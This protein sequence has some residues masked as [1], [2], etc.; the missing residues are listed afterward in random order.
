MKLI[1]KNLQTLIIHKPVIFILFSVSVIASLTAVMYL[2][3][4][5]ASIRSSTS[6]YQAAYRTVQA[7][8]PSMTK[9]GLETSLKTL[10]GGNFGIEAIRAVLVRDGQ[11]YVASYT[12]KSDN[13]SGLYF[14]KEDFYAGKK[15]IVPA[16][17]LYDKWKDLKEVKV[18]GGTYEILA[19]SDRAYS[20]IPFYSLDS[21]CEI[22]GLYM[23]LSETLSQSRLNA[24]RD[25]LTALFPTATLQLPQEPD[26][27]LASRNLY[28]S[29]SSIAVVLLALLNIS[30][31]YRYILLSRKKPYAVYRV[32]GCTRA[33]GMRLYAGEL[34]LLST[35]LF[36][37]SAAVF[38]VGIQ[39]LF[40]CINKDALTYRL[41][42]SDYFVLYLFFLLAV[43]VVFL[44]TILSFSAKKPVALLK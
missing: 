21:S 39:P 6:T 7:D 22:K 40:P 29:F 41:F 44:P 36:L 23:T 20:E 24:L 10:S 43:A 14:S 42:V 1:F 37:V 35:L 4:I 31:L 30:Y 5:H 16:K 33:R 32:C 17:S 19:F 18:L 34:F 15:Q 13:Y 11:T 9:S 27:S 2:Y 8:F 26:L 28:E 3:S 38:K 12:Y 25:K